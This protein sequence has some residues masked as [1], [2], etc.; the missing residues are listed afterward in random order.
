MKRSALTPITL[1]AI[2]LTMVL[3]ASNSPETAAVAAEEASPE[4]DIGTMKI[5]VKETRE[6]P[7]VYLLTV[8]G[9][10]Y[11]VVYDSRGAAICPHNPKETLE[12]P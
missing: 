4:P 12:E 9:E 1:A 3:I 2:L 7:K 6:D 5:I 8:E 11:V 10:T